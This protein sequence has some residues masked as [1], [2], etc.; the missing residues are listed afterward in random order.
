QTVFTPDGSYLYAADAGQTYLSQFSRDA[1]SGALTPLTPATSDVVGAPYGIAYVDNGPLVSSFMAA[2]AP[3]TATSLTYTLS[4]NRAVSGLVAGDFTVGG[5]AGGAVASVSGTGA[6]PYTIVVTGIGTGTTTLTLAK[7]ALLD[8]AGVTGPSAADA[9]RG[10][11]MSAAAPAPTILD[12]TR[13]RTPAQASNG[14]WAGEGITYTYQWQTSDTGTGNWID[15]GATATDFAPGVQCALE[16][17]TCTL[18]APRSVMYFSPVAGTYRA[19]TMSGS[20]TCNATTFGGDPASSQTKACYL[21]GPATTDTFAPTAAMLGKFVRVQVTATNAAG[22]ASATSSASVI[23]PAEVVWEAGD[24]QLT[25]FPAASNGQLAPGITRVNTGLSTVRGLALTPDQRFMYVPSYSTNQIFQYAI[26]A[27]GTDV[28]PLAPATTATTG[29][30]SPRDIVVTPDQ[31]YA[32]VINSGT[33]AVTQYSI[34]SDGT[35]TLLPTNT[36]AGPSNPYG[37]VTNATGTALYIANQNAATISQFAISRSTGQLSAMTP[38]TVTTGSDPRQLVVST[39]GKTLYAGANTGTSLS[40]FA[41]DPTTGALSA[42][43]PL[44][45]PALASSHW[46]IVSPDGA[47]VYATNFANPA[48]IGQWS[49][50]TSTGLLTALSPASVASAGA[51][52][53]AYQGVFDPAGTHLYVG[54]VNNNVLGQ[55]TR[56]PGTGLVTAMP[57]PTAGALSPPGSALQP[58]KLALVAVEPSVR[59][60]QAVPALTTSTSLSYRLLFNRAVTGL[61]AGDFVVGGTAGWTVTGVVGSGAGPYDITVAGAGTGTVDLTLTANTVADANGVVGPVLP[62]TA[63]G[64]TMSPSDVA[65]P[66]F[67]TP[68]TNTPTQST[69]GLWAGDLIAYTYQWQVSPNGTSSWSSAAGAGA[70]A[71]SYT[72]TTAELWKYLRLTVTSTNL[73]GVTSATSTAAVI[74]P[75]DVMLAST[76]EANVYSLPIRNDGALGAPFATAVAGS[77]PRQMSVSPDGQFAYVVNYSG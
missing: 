18:P 3:T 10:G 22:S 46:P 35:L 37:L 38:A 62:R 24:S 20:F 27:D 52:N 7:D 63:G 16:G 34:G 77:S 40:Q 53:Q 9:A 74:R 32:Y 57:Y 21:G 61:D 58:F 36:I 13:V 44:A 75:G 11:T 25:A 50:S 15:V 43:S 2:P 1:T 39:D 42:L 4:F 70:T 49:R 14:S 31:R 72:P 23:T 51:A 60:L 8:A 68:K 48:L 29:L 30:S 5:T 55:Y 19:A 45:A 56:N 66:T 17:G 73:A 67:V 69:N 28:T 76:S 64:G 33:Y 54:N 41:I 6:G 65:I 47:H 26:S 71:A 12:A 59:Y